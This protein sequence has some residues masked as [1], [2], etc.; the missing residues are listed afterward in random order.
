M[1]LPIELK[2]KIEEELG[3]VDIKELKESAKNISERY[4]EKTENKSKNRLINNEIEAIAYSAS[5]MPATYGAIYKALK[6]CIEV[7]KLEN[8]NIEIESLLDVGAGTGA[9]SWA[10][11]E[12]LNIK[13][14]TCIENEENMLKMYKKLISDKEKELDNIKCIKKNLIV[15]EIDEKSDLVIVSYVIN[16]ISKENR[17]KVLKKLI[18]ATNKILLIVEPGTPEGFNTIKA[19]RKYFI[20]NKEKILA[21]CPHNLECKIDENDWCS[22]SVRVARSKLHKSL[23][24]GDVPYEDE[25]F[26]YIAI[27]KDKRKINVKNIILRHPII[28][29]GKITCKLCSNKGIIEEKVITK[30]DKELFKKIKKLNSGDILN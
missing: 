1:E 17:E 23:K 16:E 12:L 4:R 10:S 13:E 9:A 27:C 26:S 19:I 20:E 29:K 8:N 22:F 18:D 7:L 11:L 6:H 14:I 5:R 24:D 3:N 21:P 15:D 30:K 25:K 28:E 2:E